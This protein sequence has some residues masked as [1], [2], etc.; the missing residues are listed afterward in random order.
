MGGLRKTVATAVIVIAVMTMT[1]CGSDDKGGAGAENTAQETANLGVVDGFFTEL[2][3]KKDPQGVARYLSDDF[4]S[5]TPT[6][7]GKQGMVDFAAFQAANHPKAGVVDDL[8][9]LAKG[10]LVVKHYTYANDPTQGAELVIADIFRVADGKIVE[11]WD[12]VATD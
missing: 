2:V 9:T 12:I 7:V 6:I 3:T 1:A 4:V 10:D 5:H 8:H 11:Y